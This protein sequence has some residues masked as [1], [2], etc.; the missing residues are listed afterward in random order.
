METTLHRGCQMIGAAEM[1]ECWRKR[2]DGEHGMLIG[3]HLRASP[4]VG[5]ALMHRRTAEEVAA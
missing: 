2:L 1:P 5:C 3:P 4:H